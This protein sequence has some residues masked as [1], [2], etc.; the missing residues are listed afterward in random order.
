[1]L[2]SIFSHCLLLIKKILVIG[3]H[4]CIMWLDK[5]WVVLVAEIKFIIRETWER[6]DSCITAD[7]LL[8]F[9]FG[10]FILFHRVLKR[11]KLI[12][13]LTGDKS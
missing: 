7:K 4:D 3:N 11:P 5:S 8:I 1:M 9:R 10:H 12:F 6:I 2:L 13:Y